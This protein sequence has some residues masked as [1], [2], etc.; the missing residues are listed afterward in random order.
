MPKRIV[1]PAKGQ[2]AL[3]DFELPV[4][5]RH[6][7]KIRTL[8]SLMSIGTETIILHQKYAPDSHFARMFSFPQLKTGVQAIGEV[9]RVGAE[10]KDF[11][12][13][14]TVF[15]RMAHGSHQV[16]SADRCSAVPDGV[17][18]KSACWCGLAKT[19]FRAAWAGRF[20]LG[21][22]VLIIGAGPVGQM[23][24]RWAKTAGLGSIVVVDLSAF[25]LDHALRGGATKTLCGDVAQHLAT[26]GEMNEGR[27]PALVVDTT[28]NPAV[29][30][31]ALSVAA[32]FGKVVLLGDTGFPG[33]Q[34]L[35]SDVMTKGL[36]IQA[37]HDSQDRDGWTQRRIDSL[38]FTSVQEGRFDLA[39]LIT[40][41]FSPEQCAAAYTLAEQ[42]REQAMGILFDWGLV[43]QATN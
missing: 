6:D 12:V 28:G 35:T 19:A 29:F 36:T 24:I 16:L 1:F 23:A 7:L 33:K 41:E 13:G 11:T 21:G 25:R 2:V 22:H 10:V 14:D 43:R 3:Q 18:L 4:A 37:T 9:E 40:H 15:M 27:G 8:Y 34:C 30:Q 42:Q 20:E 32:M 5:G 31:S 26:I 38:F 39:G 17:D